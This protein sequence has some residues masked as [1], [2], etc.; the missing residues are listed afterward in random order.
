MKLEIVAT[1][2]GFAE[3]PIYMADGS[4]VYV[5][6]RGGT[7]GRVSMQGQVEVITQLGG[8]PNGAAVG[9][10]GA[11]Y[12][13]NNGGLEW[14]DVNG[15]TIP[16][17]KPHD[18][19]G[20]SIQRVDLATGEVTTLYTECGGRPLRGPN[21]IVF[22]MAGGFWFSDLGKSDEWTVDRGALYY[23]LPDGSKIVRAR[24]GLGS[25]NGVGLSP[26]QKVLYVAETYTGRLWAY[27][28]LAPG[29][30][31]P[32]PAPW[33]SG[34][35]IATLPGFEIL[36]SLTIEECGNVCVAGGPEGRITVFDSH[37]KLEHHD[38]PGEVVVTNLCF[39][40][41]DMCDAWITAAG[42]GRLYKARW[43]RP[44][45]KLNYSG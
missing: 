19:A 20:G 45:L 18:Y 30:L 27:D 12:V 17:H 5:D 39:G 37:G 28:I 13:C 23:A 14:H 11:V 29:I 2:L 15:L 34:R 32:P 9:N 4:I 10:D 8:G 33:L 31:A 16:G 36:D 24:G 1:G 21:D 25:P 40:G 6:I 35:L 22:D 43:P 3:G 7:L 42:T 38:L 41:E 26:D 44:G